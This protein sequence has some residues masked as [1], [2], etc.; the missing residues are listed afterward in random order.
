MP[1]KPGGEGQ[2]ERPDRLESATPIHVPQGS[3]EPI[4]YLGVHPNT[5]L[6]NK[7]PLITVENLLILSCLY[8]VRVL[9]AYHSC[10]R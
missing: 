4:L 2:R 8:L 9:M 6:E 1:R 5:A 10:H 7:I 3:S